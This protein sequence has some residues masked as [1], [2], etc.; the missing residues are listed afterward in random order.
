MRRQYVL[1]L[2]CLALSLLLFGCGLPGHAQ[3]AA[4]P[5]PA[6]DTADFGEAGSVIAA[7]K[8]M[9][10][11]TLVFVFD[12]SGSMEDHGNLRRIRQATINILREGTAPGDH[13][14]LLTFGA[15]NHNVF[16][17]TI[18]T[19]ADIA[20][21]IDKVP[22]HVE[23]GAGTNIRKPH[24][25]ALKIIDADRPQPGVIVLLTDS[26][27]DQPNT[28]D[29]TYPGYLKYYTP[30]GQLTKYPNRPENRDYERLLRKLVPSGDLTQFGV[31]IKIADNGR[32]IERLPQAAPPPGE[33]AAD[34]NSAVD[35]VPP[36]S[37]VSPV[38]YIVGGLALLALIGGAVFLAPLTRASALR[39]TG[40]PGGAKDY[41]IRNGQSVRVG[42]EGAAVAWD[43][44]PV[45]TKQ[46]VALVKSARGQLFIGLGPGKGNQPTPPRVYHNGVEL[47]RDEPLNFGD[48]VRVALT[49][50]IGTVK[51]YRLK[52]EDPR[53]SY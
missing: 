35:T 53:K 24:H 3:G 41:Q 49:S 18:T 2:I 32:P 13:V 4:P 25:E 33:P 26:F 50:D 1:P 42:G 5:A 28:S 40:G 43:A 46:A 37:P 10:R 23:P 34:T 15:D 36:P 19:R 11:K 22:S 6:A 16:D 51:E 52:F 9:K 47:S 20:G 31:G 38:I 29:A 48:E 8:G 45:P 21:L 17:T 7:L 30:G 27:N 44:Y 14:A 39:I 12:V